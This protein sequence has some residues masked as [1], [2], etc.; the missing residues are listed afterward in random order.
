MNACTTSEPPETIDE[1]KGATEPTDNFA[2]CVDENVTVTLAVSLINGSRLPLC[3]SWGM[4][5]QIFSEVLRHTRQCLN[6]N[7]H[8]VFIYEGASAHG[9]PDSLGID[10]AL[11]MLP[12]YSPFLN[13]VE[14]AISTH[15]AAIKA[16]I[17]HPEIQTRMNDREE[18]RRQGVTLGDYRGQLLLRTTSGM[19]VLDITPHTNA[20]S[21]TV[22]CKYAFPGT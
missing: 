2:D 4:N 17:S 1:R 8:V 18:A 16:D 13:I 12:A 7:W 10:V 19:S 11:R 9:N 21:G 20:L 22:S 3:S 15:K 5:A 6:P 14:Q